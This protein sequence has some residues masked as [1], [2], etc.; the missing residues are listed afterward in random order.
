MES[1]DHEKQ[2]MALPIDFS[3]LMDSIEPNVVTDRNGQEM[4]KGAN[5]NAHPPNLSQTTSDE[6]SKKTKGME[7]L[8]AIQSRESQETIDGLQ[9][10]SNAYRDE[11]Q[12]L[13]RKHG[14]LA[15][16]LEE[17]INQKDREL[18]S[19]MLMIKKSYNYMNEKTLEHE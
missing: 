8:L 1:G 11:V 12:R 4:K 19:H 3:L 16:Q 9:K 10:E 2:S 6:Y 13:N 5:S 17:I 15:A 14:D 7:N 18:T